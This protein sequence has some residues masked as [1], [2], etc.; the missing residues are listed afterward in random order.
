M[1][2][3]MCL[4]PS[5][6]FRTPALPM[7]KKSSKPLPSHYPM[8]PSSINQES[9]DPNFN[10][11]KCVSEANLA[12]PLPHQDMPN[13]QYSSCD[14]TDEIHTQSDMYSCFNL[15]SNNSGSTVIGPSASSIV[16]DDFCALKN[17]D[18]QT[19][20]DFLGGNFCSN[21]DVQSQITSASL[22]DSQTFSLQEYADNSGGASSSNVDFEDSNILQHSSWKQVTPRFRTY[23]KVRNL[24]KFSRWGKKECSF[25]NWLGCTELTDQ[26]L[27]DYIYQ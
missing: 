14:L 6:S 25:S 12:A 26:L 9:W 10:D 16:L 27:P 2:P 21:Q 19:P 1:Y 20:S 5:G 3:P 13:F 15:D 7:V 22:V 18:F 24:W 23:T 8:L 17:A 4:S 11:A